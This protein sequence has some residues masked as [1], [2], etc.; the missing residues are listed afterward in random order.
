MNPPK[1]G[2]KDSDGNQ[3]EENADASSET[4]SNLFVAILASYAVAGE[5]RDHIHSTI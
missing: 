1:K 2:S 3:I 4:M 5:S